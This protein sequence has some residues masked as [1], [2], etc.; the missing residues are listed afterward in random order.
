[1]LPLA[2]AHYS[3]TLPVALHPNPN[4]TA[5]LNVGNAANAANARR[6]TARLKGEGE[7]LKLELEQLNAEFAEL[8]RRKQ[9]C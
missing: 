1:M 2:T 5:H 8:K 9:A 4:P 3:T 7:Q 6:K